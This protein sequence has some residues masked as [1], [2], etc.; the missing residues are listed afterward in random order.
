MTFSSR[1]Q[2][3]PTSGITSFTVDSV[4]ILACQN[5]RRARYLAYVPILFVK[6]WNSAS[7]LKE[8]KVPKRR[9]LSSDLS[10]ISRMTQG[11]K[12]CDEV[13]KIQT[14]EVHVV[15]FGTKDC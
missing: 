10:L 12:Y 9:R 7:S 3:P 14:Q 13:E 2:L 11:Q 8:R 5:S 1:V 15:L 6:R 4:S